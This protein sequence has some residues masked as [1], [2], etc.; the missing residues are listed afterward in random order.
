MGDVSDAQLDDGIAI[1]EIRPRVTTLEGQVGVLASRQEQVMTKVGEVED[2]VLEMQGKVNNYLCDQVDGSREDVDGLL[3]LKE[4]VQT[5]ES[6]VQELRKE[7]QKLRGLLSA[8]EGD[9]SVLASYVF[10]LGE[11]LAMMELQFPGP[12]PGPQ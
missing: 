6:T 5:L 8:R 9:Q 7:N 1:G 11:R 2:R 3:G 10:G 12:P 4:R